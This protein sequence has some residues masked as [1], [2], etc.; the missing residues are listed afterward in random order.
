MADWEDGYWWSKDGLRLHYRDYRGPARSRQLPVIC[1]PGLTR[2]ARDFADVAL[3]LSAKRR[4]IAVELRGRGESAPAKDPMTYVPA[5]Y[6]EDLAALIGQAALDLDRFILFGTS[7]GGILSMLL[8]AANQGKVAGVLLN[9]IGPAIEPA[10]LARIRNYIGKSSSH[11]TWLHAARALQDLHRGAYPDY[12]LEQWLEM[13]KRLSRLTAAGRIVSDYDSAIAEPFK[14]PG[15]EAGVDLWPMLEALKPIP[16][17]LVRG[18]LSDI[19]STATAD[20][21]AAELPLMERL[22]IPRTGHAPTLAEPGCDAAIDRLLSRI[23]KA[24]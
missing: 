8:T 13:A 10:G 16:S 5:T 19:I 11:P 21:M 6:F 15:G 18:K 17:L 23:A 9:D 4:V 2:N 22:D 1:I 20:R 3:R 7:L 24:A 12:N 14:V